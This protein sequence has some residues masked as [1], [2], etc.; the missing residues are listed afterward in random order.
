MT[1]RRAWTRAVA[2]PLVAVAA[3]AVLGTGLASA[4]SPAAS[5][6]RAGRGP[7]VAPAAATSVAVPG[8]LKPVQVGLLSNQERVP[9]G[10]LREVVDGLVVDVDWAVLQPQRDGPLAAGNEIDLALAAVRELRAAG[11]PAMTLK[12]RVLAGTSAPEWAKR[13]GGA[14]VQIR[15]DRTGGDSGSKGDS[16]T[17]GRFWTPAFG[18]AYEQLQDRLAAAYDDEPEILATSITRCTTFYG[19]PFLRQAGAPSVARALYAAG[20]TP[21]EDLRC[22]RESLRAHDAWGR[23]RSALSLNPYQAV[24]ADGTFTIDVDL[25]LRLA[26]ECRLALGQ[27]C[28]LENHSLRWPVQTGPYTALYDGMRALGG[29]LSLQ[30]AAPARMSDW[31]RALDWGVQLGADSMELNRAYPRYDLAELARIAGLLRACG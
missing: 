28:Q 21:R 10:S 6:D 8:G 5:G 7:V 20:F 27:A 22:L 4:S 11:H 23:T 15:D 3:A 18:T 1:R 29:P 19:E 16:G 12:L 26:R 14:P 17:V 30:S 24:Q 2:T 31:R 9:P 13:L 25:T